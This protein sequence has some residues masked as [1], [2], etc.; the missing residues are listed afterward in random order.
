MFEEHGIKEVREEESLD[1][2]GGGL[3]DIG[4]S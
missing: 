4:I 3:N 2:E 1:T